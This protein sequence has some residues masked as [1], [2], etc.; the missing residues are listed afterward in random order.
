MS[1]NESSNTAWKQRV[2]PKEEGPTSLG[3][4]PAQQLK[5]Y[6]MKGKEKGE[7]RERNLWRKTDIGHKETAKTASKEL[8]LFHNQKHSEHPTVHHQNER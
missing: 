5:G 3:Y 7:K 1:L 8:K 2:D 6:N 4:L